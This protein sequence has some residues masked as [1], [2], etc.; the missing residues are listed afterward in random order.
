MR[1]RILAALLLAL[2]AFG[3]SGTAWAQPA[4]TG[5]PNS[6]AA[7]GDSITR[8]YDADSA[9]PP[10]ERLQYSWATG[11]SSRVS[12]LYE[13]I[14]AVHS[15]ISGNAFNDAATGANMV[16]LAGQVSNAVS[17]HAAEVVILMGGNDAC[18]ST[19]ADMT[20]V[21]TYRSQ[22]AS[23]MKALSLGLPDARIYVLSVPDVY[24]LWVVLHTNPA[25]RSVWS[26]ASICQSLLANPTSTA[27]ADVKR[28]AAVRARV[29]HFNTQLKQV[30]AL[31][32]HCRFDGDAV[33]NNQFTASD[34]NTL[35]YFHPSISGQAKLAGVAW[36]NGFD[37]GDTT[38]PV[39]TATVTP[40]TG[41]ATVTLSATDNAGVSGIEYRIGSGRYF[42]YAGPLTV[43]TGK[44]I[45]WRAVDVNG[46]TEAT[47][48]RTI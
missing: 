4:I 13:R 10:G 19:Q 31:Y 33:F 44:T 43:A 16:D 18:T 40:V 6:I 15:A 27:A 45:T 36:S 5:Y 21:A 46:N 9:F 30:C 28:R 7:T 47:H 11:T 12:S 14:L 20:P 23:A 42:R 8:G 2:P 29:V 3:L 48:T 41:G 25:A 17:Q 35:D 22:F 24:Q 34:V 26:A 39:S 1:R 37:F 38:P 32:V